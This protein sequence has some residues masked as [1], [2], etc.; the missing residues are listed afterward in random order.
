[1]RFSIILHTII[2][3][4]KL[5]NRVRIIVSTFGKILCIIQFFTSVAYI[6]IKKDAHS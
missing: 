6:V 4:R 5:R 2:Y 3:N 1:M